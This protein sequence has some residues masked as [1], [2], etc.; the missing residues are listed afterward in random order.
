MVEM[1]PGC[2]E[3]DPEFMMRAL[4]VGYIMGIR[5]ERHLCGEDNLNLAY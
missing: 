2:P 3:I 1:D 4:V 5:S